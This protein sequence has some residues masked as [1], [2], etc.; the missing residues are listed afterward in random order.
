MGVV[1]KAEATGWAGN[2]ALKFVPDGLPARRTGLQVLPPE[3]RAACLESPPYLHRDIKPGDFFATHP[4]AGKG[5]RFPA[6]QAARS[7]A[8]GSRGHGTTHASRNDLRSR[9]LADLPAGECG[10]I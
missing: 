3:V 6:R 9:P 8:A 5:P 10:L 1:Y 2:V 4:A 7:R